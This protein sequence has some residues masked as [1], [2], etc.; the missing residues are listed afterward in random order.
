MYLCLSVCIYIYIYIYRIYIYIYTY[1]YIYIYIYIFIT[2]SIF[3]STITRASCKWCTYEFVIYIHTYVSVYVCIYIHATQSPHL[4]SF[5]QFILFAFFSSQSSPS[6]KCHHGSYPSSRSRKCHYA[7]HSISESNLSIFIRM[8]TRCFWDQDTD[9]SA[10]AT[11]SNVRFYCTY[12]HTCMQT[13]I[14]IMMIYSNGTLVH[15]VNKY[16]RGWKR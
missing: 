3:F 16:T 13:Y 6:R 8:G 1:I 10:S 11:F 4:A 7:S 15:N 2:S 9:N 5:S 12:I 14:H